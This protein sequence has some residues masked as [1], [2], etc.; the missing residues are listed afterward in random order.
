MMDPEGAS[1][2]KPHAAE[3]ARGSGPAIGKVL[4]QALAVFQ[5]LQVR[6][7]FVAV[8]LII[9]LIVGQWDN[10]RDYWAK[11]NRTGMVDGASISP[12]TEYW[13]PMCPGVTSDWPGKCPVCNMALIRRAKGE[14]TPR[15]DGTL[16]RMQLAPYRVQLAGVHT[17]PVEF[18][19][20]AREIV[21]AGLLEAGKGAD[22]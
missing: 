10:F 12:S 9:F 22:G 8:F 15:P 21:L 18:R 4:R 19:P 2:G 5:V 20:L 3:L 14:M 11:F 16:A 1:N 7:R 6:L 17:S 13:C